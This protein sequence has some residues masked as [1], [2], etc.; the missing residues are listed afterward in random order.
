ML[1]SS[2][3]FRPLY[4]YLTE[5]KVVVRVRDIPPRIPCA[6]RITVGTPEQ[7]DRL[8]QLLADFRPED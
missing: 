4:R 3:Y 5:H 7:N 8:E 6:L 1:A 2:P